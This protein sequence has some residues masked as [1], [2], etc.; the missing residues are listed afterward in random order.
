M[1]LAYLPALQ[2]CDRQDL[3]LALAGKNVLLFD[4]SANCQFSS[5]LFIRPAISFS[6]PTVAAVLVKLPYW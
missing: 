3:K 2:G 6:F 4:F 5:I 1:M